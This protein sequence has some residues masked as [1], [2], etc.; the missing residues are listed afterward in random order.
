[1]PTS[2]LQFI[3]CN[4]HNEIFQA[5]HSLVD[6][7]LPYVFSKFVF[8]FVSVVTQHQVAKAVRVVLLV[9]SGSTIH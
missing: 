9:F 4:A 2:P 8:K 5:L 1:M 3:S 6:S 7:R